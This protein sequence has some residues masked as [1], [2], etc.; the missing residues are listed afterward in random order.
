M[1]DSMCGKP[2]L[3]IG[4]LYVIAGN[5]HQHINLCNFIQEYSELTV[6]Q[7]RGLSGIY[8]HGCHCPVSMSN[9]SFP[10]LNLTKYFIFTVQSPLRK[11]PS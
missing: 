7:K 5:S 10:I 8:Q 3:R 4:K 2:N 9:S 1:D 6:V 11:Q